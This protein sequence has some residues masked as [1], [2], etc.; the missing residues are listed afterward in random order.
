MYSVRKSEINIYIK[1]ILLGN[2]IISKIFNI[3]PRQDR[4]KVLSVVVLQVLFGVLDLIGVGLIG[5]IGAL[6]V[7]GIQSRP[8]TGRILTILNF[9]NIDSC[10][11]Q[12]QV[13]ILGGISC[14]ILILRTFLSVKFIRKIYHFLSKKS[15]LISENL[16]SKLLNQSLLVINRNSSQE[17]LFSI[18]T[19]VTTLT[20]GVI[21]ALVNLVSDISLFLIMMIGL[22]IV[23]PIIALTSILIFS[24]VGIVMYK[25]THKRAHQL[26]LEGTR[27]SVLS[28]EKILEVIY[29][30]R[31]AFVRNR[32]DFYAQEIAKDRLELSA[33]LA[34]SSF[35]PNVSKYVIE[36]SIMISA[37]LI[38]SIQFAIQDASHAVAT[39]S[40]F[41]A[42]G[43]RIAPAVLRIQQNILGIRNSMGSSQP[44][45]EAIDRL[46]KV[47]K[48][49]R[50]SKLI[51]TEH[52]DFFA[53]LN[54]SNLKFNYGNSNEFSININELEIKRGE[55]VAIVGP[56]GS[57]K[58]TLVDVI[59][60]ILVPQEGQITISGELPIEAIRKW[61]GAIAYVPQE[62]RVM[63]SSIRRN[64]ALG[65]SDEV[66]NLQLVKEALDNA[67]LS[68]FVRELPNGDTTII[69][70]RGLRLSGGQKQRIGIARALF[71]KPLF[72]VMD[73]STSALDGETE[74]LISNKIKEFKGKKTL[75]FV[76]HR[77]S[78]I[79]DFDK[80]IYLDAGEIKSVGTF[81]Q[82]RSAVKEFDTQAKL[83]GL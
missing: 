23:N 20:I 47:E 65:F 50:T 56:S 3:L 67:S 1:N 22:F 80:I 74:A 42:A 66:I 19:G 16:I 41:L 26:G 62:V 37:L 33:I 10:S 5:L 69:G 13:A 57:G 39:L 2:S 52:F 32:R 54:I 51:D 46:E 63:N 83:M 77:L 44:T 72:I 35:L 18:T 17:I 45:L 25:I 81:S 79:R 30:Y 6:T 76:A 34:E 49:P 27:L 28:N 61:P 21:G 24:S 15:A 71:T 53:D 82:V 43:T 11:F 73:E 4:I 8:A 68:E 36:T 31:E 64:V 78:T 7:N 70:E 40:I 38:A 29:T 14:F 12:L 59:L 48:L 60:G 9:F 55:F 75:I 58:S